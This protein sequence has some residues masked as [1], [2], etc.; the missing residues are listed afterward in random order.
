MSL[1]G[2]MVSKYSPQNE[3]KR[4]KSEKTHLD[5]EDRRGKHKH[6]HPRCCKQRSKLF[7]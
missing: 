4:T 2:F 6:K 3:E 5:I 7:I 1:R